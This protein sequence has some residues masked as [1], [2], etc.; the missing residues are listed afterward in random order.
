MPN[1]IP[2]G[3]SCP[4]DFQRCYVC[5]EVYCK[6]QR[7]GTRTNYPTCRKPECRAEAIRR[8]NRE[9]ESRYF[10]E[11]GEYRSRSIERARPEMK[12]RA[13]ER[14]RRRNAEIPVRRRYPAS[15]EARDTRRRMRKVG[16]EGVVEV[17]DRL[18][19]F[20]AGEWVCQLCKTAVDP[21]LKYPDP[22]SASL[23]HIQP[24]SLGGS[25]TR[26]NVQLAHLECNVRKSNKPS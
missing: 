11:H 8:R 5:E 13:A 3:P 6:R 15:F 24:L 17:I 4:V 21:S 20:A 10:A 1:R 2:A 18:E 14:N 12:A 22:L 23:D 19:V 9:R 16:A 25:H 26:A 7:G